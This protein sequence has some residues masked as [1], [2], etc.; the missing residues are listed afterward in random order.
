MKPNE[1]L[2]QLFGWEPLGRG[3]DWWNAL[4]DHRVQGFLADQKLDK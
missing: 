2:P 1:A 4:F 3:Q